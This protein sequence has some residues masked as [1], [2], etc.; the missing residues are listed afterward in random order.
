MAMDLREFTFYKSVLVYIM[1]NKTNTDND[2]LSVL[3]MTREK[4]GR[5]NT[6]C[7]IASFTRKKRAILKKKVIVDLGSL[8]N[9]D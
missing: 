7:E 3:D 8:S 1:K 4:I 6:M 5:H 2:M 9:S